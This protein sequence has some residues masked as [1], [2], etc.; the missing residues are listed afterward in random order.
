MNVSFNSSFMVISQDEMLQWIRVLSPVPTL[1]N[2]DL[3]IMLFVSVHDLWP[4]L[5]LIIVHAS[6]GYHITTRH[7]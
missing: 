7:N 2:P 4:K 5:T 3:V 6:S 1:L